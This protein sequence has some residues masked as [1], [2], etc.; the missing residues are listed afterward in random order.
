[1]NLNEKLVGRKKQISARWLD[2]L[3]ST[4][5]SQGAKF[6]K[7]TS[8]EFANPVGTTFHAS[9][10]SLVGFLLQGERGDGI[11]NAVDGL[12]RIRAVQGFAPSVATGFVFAIKK[13]LQDEAGSDL[14]ASDGAREWKSI[15]ARIDE[16][17]CIA[18]DLYM[19]CREKIWKH[20]ANH[21]YNRT[22]KLLIKS[23]LIEE[24]TD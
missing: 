8:N 24:V 4:Y 13:I 20:K 17:T 1:M 7:E 11:E 14:L 16:M 9:L 18:F 15:E 19:Q 3:L 5:K 23:H 22:S 6:F 12:V 10:D 2:A 21:L